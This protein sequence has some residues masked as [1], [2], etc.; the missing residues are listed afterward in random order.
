MSEKT[1]YTI[2]RAEIALAG[3]VTIVADVSSVDD[4]KELVKD[5]H[6]AGFGEAIRRPTDESPARPDTGKSDDP[7]RRIEMQAGL[8]AGRLGSAK[9]LAVK[10]GIPQLL[11]KTIFTS[12]T[13]AILVLMY[14]LEAGLKQNPVNYDDFS[15]LFESQNLKTGSPI[16]MLLTNLRNAQYLDSRTYSDGRKL[17]LTAKG[18]KKAIEVLKNLATR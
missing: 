18:E 2:T 6:A 1:R 5:L 8:E 13:D 14:A 17:R 3:G 4:V 9:I 15:A 11:Q 10:D 12:V 7:A 16:S